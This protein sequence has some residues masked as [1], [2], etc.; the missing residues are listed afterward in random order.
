M[1]PCD[2]TFERDDKGKPALRMPS[3]VGLHFSVS[4]SGGTV[5]VAVT[6]SRPVGVDIEL[7]QRRRDIDSLVEAILS[8]AEMEWLSARS[9]CQRTA[10]FYDLWVAKEAA[11][12]LS[13]RGLSASFRDTTLQ[14]PGAWATTVQIPDWGSA[15]VCYLP[16]GPHLSAAVTTGR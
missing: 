8:P 5:A 6:H 16:V 9:P 13:G 1:S 2:R 11:A 7:H 4:R 3:G 12:K 10:T 14:S 15:R